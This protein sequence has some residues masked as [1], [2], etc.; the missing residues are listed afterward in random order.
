M[1]VLLN[2]IILSKG[3]PYQLWGEQFEYEGEYEGKEYYRY[4][5][6]DNIPQVGHY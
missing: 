1:C 5:G 6:Y 3:T 2:I 4:V